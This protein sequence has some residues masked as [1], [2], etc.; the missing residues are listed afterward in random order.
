MEDPR[1][2]KWTR[3]LWVRVKNN[4]MPT[5]DEMLFEAREQGDRDRQHGPV[6]TYPLMRGKPAGT[7]IP[8]GM[9][10]E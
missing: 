2:R 5:L 6:R 1:M 9:K 4:R 3:H 10:P 7:P 8:K